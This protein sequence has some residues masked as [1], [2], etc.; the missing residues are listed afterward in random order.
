[1][2]KTKIPSLSYNAMFKAVFSN[3]KG[4]LSK[5]IEAILAYCKIDINVQDKEL[6]IRNNELPLE[7][8]QDRQLICDFIIKL[9]EHLDLN[10]EVNKSYY[11]GLTKKESNI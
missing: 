11:P 3:N 4:I 1:M 9:N 5:L 10:I 8:Y 6:I 2:K 7:N